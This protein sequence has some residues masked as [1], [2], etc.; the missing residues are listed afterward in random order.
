MLKLPHLTLSNPYTP[1]NML[2]IDPFFG[3]GSTSAQ[4]LDTHNMMRISDYNPNIVNYFLAIKRNPHLFVQHLQELAN[5]HSLSL[6][7]L[8]LYNTRKHTFN[9]IE[10]QYQLGK[11]PDYSLEFRGALKTNHLN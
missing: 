4:F 9:E 5:T 2:I 11:N 3:S 10:S 7:K 6:N 8:Q 1:P